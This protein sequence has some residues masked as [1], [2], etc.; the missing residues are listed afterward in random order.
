M[1]AP[2]QVFV[3]ATSGDL[4]SVRQLVSQALLTI[5]CHPVEQSHFGPDYRE[6]RKM[7]GD[8][9]AECQALIH[10]VG[11]RYGAE[12]DPARL[13]QGAERRSYTQMEYDLGRELQRKRGDGR[14]RV[15]TFVCPEGFPFDA[16]PE[17]EDDEKRGLQSAHRR[18]IL[19][20]EILYET[21]A[22][23]AGLEA[24][25]HALREEARR[26]RV[27]HDRHRG[28]MLAV[29]AVICIALGLIGYGV[30]QLRDDT[31]TLH[32][33]G[34]EQTQLMLDA[35]AKLEEVIAAT[36]QQG[37]SREPLTP[38]QRYDQALQEVAFRH[39][40]K[41]DELRAAIDAWTHKVK[42]DPKSSPYDLAL[43]EYKANHFEQAA[44]QAG[45]AYDQAMEARGQATQDAIKAARL[46]GNAYEAQGHYD[47][48][49]VAY[50]KS[51]ALTDKVKEP[52]AWADEQE[53]VAKMLFFLARHREAEP[54]MRDIL[55]VREQHLSAHHPDTARALNNLAQLLQATN[56][57]AE[58][59]PLMRRA[60]AIDERSYGPEHPDVARAL[61]NLAQLLQATNR[62][63]EAEPLMR[64]ALAI[65][66]RSYGPEHPDVARALNNLA[67]LLQATNR[68]AEAEP[69]MRR[70]LAI[71]ERSYGPE[72]PDVAR[73]L[74]NLAQLLQATNRLAEA[75]PL[76]RRALA[77][78]E[79]SYGPEHPDVAR[80][81]NNLAQLL[82]ATNRLAEAEPLMRRALAIDERSYG[83]EH[84][85]VA[86][87]LNNLAQLLQATNRL[88]EAEPLM[89][90]AL[91]IDERSYGP[92]HPDVARDLN[93]LAQLLQATNRLAEAEP[94][95]RR[96]L[97][98]DERS[99]GPEHPDVARDLNNLAQLLQA[100]N[101]LAE[102]EP[103]MRRALAIDERSYGPE[104]PDVARDLNNLAQLLQATNRLAEA[105]PL[106]RRA[107]AI[108]E[109][110]YG[111]EHPDVAIDLNNLAQLLQ[112]TNRLAEAEPLSRR[113]IVIFLKFQRATGHKHPN[114][115][116]AIINYRQLLLAQHLPEAKIQT[117]LTEAAK[118]A[119]YGAAE[120]ATMQAS[121]EGARV[122]GIVPGSQA[123]RLGVQ[124]GD[125][126]IRYAGQKI[127]S[128]ARLV[129]LVG[130]AKDPAIPLTL[131]RD[132]KPID[133]SAQ[134]GKLGVRLQ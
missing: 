43:A 24:R 76:M 101:R 123:E 75:E 4:R 111:P 39:D 61:N 134:P 68:L 20:G 71:D 2:P 110:S 82:Q 96:A 53:R 93:N 47:L 79:R 30:W 12:P 119:G 48:A 80:D 131:V 40:L 83:P 8:R 124:P 113:M 70:A 25:I 51:A 54:I 126:I 5:G 9:I 32:Q 77:I 17:A 23:P 27:E 85:D 11:F 112:A 46:E 29:G 31:R 15:Y 7:L 35:R 73:D 121:L 60:L 105:E 107:L 122:V 72:H 97:A 106:M 89:R 103:L 45:K 10:I 65:D 28:T 92:E 41:P 116:Q 114:L 129:E 55:A 115:R 22:D 58:A 66:E 34:Q 90:R 21:P 63:A 59:E 81:L 94:L 120:W 99:Y 84:P 87:D 1:N 102:A 62:L 78:D 132:G 108:D 49:L 104:H 130:Q 117:R 42:A 18:A 133:L 57:L 100:T 38:Q 37:I 95:M 36:R 69:L 26:L 127:T 56:R 33:Q 74:N 3:S 50:R 6:V 125:A 128:N 98:I 52:L 14:F 109:Q 88:A 118:E 19:G 44:T 86:R 13:P 67:Q 91:A 16:E 64:R